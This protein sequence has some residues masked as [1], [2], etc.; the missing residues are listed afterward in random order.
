MM[1]RV[2]YIQAISMSQ[3]LWGKGEEMLQQNWI[4]KVLNTDCRRTL[5]PGLSNYFT[6][7]LFFSKLIG[8][9]F[10]ESVVGEKLN[11]SS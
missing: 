6:D 3:L 9:Y 11:A 1:K 8:Y 5:I 10:L 2:L 7:S 4:V